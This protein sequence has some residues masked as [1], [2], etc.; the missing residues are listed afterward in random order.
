MKKRNLKLLRK[1]KQVVPEVDEQIVLTPAEQAEAARFR[2]LT[3]KKAKHKAAVARLIS[4]LQGS[5]EI[6]NAA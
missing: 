5:D 6:S 2:A 4:K 1:R 3:T